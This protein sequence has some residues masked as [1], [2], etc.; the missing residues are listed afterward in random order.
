M[1]EDADTILVMQPSW[2]HE[3]LILV[4]LVHASASFPRPHFDSLWGG[5]VILRKSVSRKAEGGEKR[6]DHPREPNTGQALCPAYHGHFVIG[7]PSCAVGQLLAC[8]VYRW[9]AEFLKLSTLP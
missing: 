9:R 8:L 2:C 7:S 3:I 6:L 1:A 5:S 4:I